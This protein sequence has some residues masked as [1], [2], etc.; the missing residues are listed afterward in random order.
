[1]SSACYRGS[2]QTA[3]LRLTIDSL[4]G[5]P[6][7]TLLYVIQN[8]D[9]TLAASWPDGQ[10]TF[11]FPVNSADAQSFFVAGLD[12]C[13]EDSVS[14][15]VAGLDFNPPSPVTIDSISYDGPDLV[16]SW[17]VV[18]D[19]D[20]V[21]YIV[22]EVTQRNPAQ[23]SSFAELSGADTSFLRIPAF[24][25]STSE[26]TTFLVTAIDRCGIE[27]QSNDFHSTL[28]I[29]SISNVGCTPNYRIFAPEPEGLGASASYVARLKNLDNNQIERVEM[30][31]YSNPFQLEGLE[32]FTPYELNLV[33]FNAGETVSQSSNMVSFT[34]GAIPYEGAL[35]LLDVRRSDN[36]FEVRSMVEP[37]D[38]NFTYAIFWVG[39]AGNAGRTEILSASDSI[40]N[41]F[42][43]PSGNTPY[44]FYVGALDICDFITATSDSV[45]V[46]I[47]TL[48]T[49]EQRIDI[50]YA[51][52]V[53]QTYQVFGGY[54]TEDFEL[55]D[56]DAAFPYSLPIDTDTLRSTYCV[57]LEAIDSLTGDLIFRSDSQC[58]GL[59]PVVH[60]PNAIR[61][62][63]VEE[64]GTF[65]IFG[66]F[67]DPSS[68]TLRIYNRWGEQIFS[69]DGEDALWKGSSQD[70]EPV[71]PGVY[72]YRVELF[73]NDRKNYTYDGTI[74]VFR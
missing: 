54:Q 56:N 70:G 44:S 20:V 31:S 19:S 26:Q 16:L 11:S 55:L 35:S 14:S 33:A 39:S 51:S 66:S 52:L 23:F 2:D 50:S 69:E 58:T 17:Q 27:S 49:R 10:S 71:Q 48:Q 1:M 43:R 24:L 29:D 21:G 72:F 15:N 22:N 9:T 40:Q 12:Y 8:G 45:R 41:T 18:N 73:G 7:E 47:P 61:L 62:N 25:D 57:Y 53:G 38:P 63:R 30:G 32:R 4:C 34:A 13:G 59:Q 68:I 3:N 5:I 65:E 37:P 36:A 28:Y 60:I 67:F 42:V 46:G 74:Q 64:T 6:D